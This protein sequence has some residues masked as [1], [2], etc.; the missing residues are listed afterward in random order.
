MRG[1]IGHFL[2]TTVEEV[3]GRVILTSQNI[4][5]YGAFSPGDRKA[6]LMP[7]AHMTPVMMHD[8]VIIE[9]HPFAA[10]VDGTIQIHGAP[11]D[12]RLDRFSD[13]VVNP[14]LPRVGVRSMSEEVLR[15]DDI[16]GR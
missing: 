6:T 13:R 15:V 1:P 9:G 8:G 4:G 5:A 7:I 2:F 12:C 14:D 3:E 16:V 11:D 10:S